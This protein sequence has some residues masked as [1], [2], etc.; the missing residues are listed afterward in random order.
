MTDVLYKWL[1]DDNTRLCKCGHMEYHHRP[2]CGHHEWP[3]T[4]E[5]NIYCGCPVFDARGEK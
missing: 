5:G 1:N 2:E 3:M 4:A